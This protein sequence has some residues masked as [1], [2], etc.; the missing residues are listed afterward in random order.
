LN[1]LLLF[2]FL[3]KEASCDNLLAICA[4]SNEWDKYEMAVGKMADKG[5]S[6]EKNTYSCILKECFTQ[7]NGV[8]AVKVLNLMQSHSTEMKPNQDDLKLAIGALCRNNKYERGLWKKALQLI[9]L[10]A[11]AIE[12]GDMDISLG[13]LHVDAYNEVLQCMET[14]K[15]WEDALDLLEM[16][17]AGSGFHASPNQGTYHRVL[18][19]LISSSQVDTAA[20][21]LFTLSKERQDSPTIYLYEIVLSAL[22]DKR[23]RNVKWQQAIT[24]LDSMHELKISIPTVMFNKVIAACAKAKQTNAARDLFHKMKAQK[25]QPDTVTYNSLISVAANTGR[26]KDALTLFRMC[27]EDTGVDIITYTNTIR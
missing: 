12:R 4:A 21:L 27:N 13:T 1:L 10:A 16:M 20:E 17:E 23:Q 14:H 6:I 24:L 11:A 26:A 5:I 22:L 15:R 19:A 2:S 25:V 3:W 9:H 7:G 18:N 8:S